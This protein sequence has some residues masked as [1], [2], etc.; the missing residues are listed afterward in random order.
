MTAKLRKMKLDNNMLLLKTYIAGHL[1]A[2]GRF[3][4]FEHLGFFF[5]KFQ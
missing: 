4:A 2:S 5:L 3:D 1:G